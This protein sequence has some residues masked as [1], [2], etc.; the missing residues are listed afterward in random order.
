MTAPSPT[1][2][3]SLST[4]VQYLK[5]VGPERAE[6]LQRIELHTVTDVLFVVNA[7]RP[8]AEDLA[9]LR[10]KLDAVQAAARVPVTGL[11]ANTH[12]M[13]ETTL[14]TVRQGVRVA[15][16]LGGATGIPVRFCA[17]LKALVQAFEASEEAAS[18]LPILALER[19]IVPPFAVASGRAHRRS[20]GV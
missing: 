1:P 15:R 2:A 16:Q 13:E 14:E 20:P 5:G 7:N 11:V 12:L 18:R 17:M 19:H 3:K 8:F 4:P 10:K 6:L 9:A